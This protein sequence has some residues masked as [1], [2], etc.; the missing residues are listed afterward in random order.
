MIQK[1]K[2]RYEQYIAQAREARRKA[3]LCD[4]LFG[5]GNDPRKNPCHD[6]FY[7]AVGQWVSAF[8]ASN[9]NPED[10]AEAVAWILQAAYLNREQRDVY[11]YL[12]A[13][14]G[15]ALPLIQK[16]FQTDAKALLDWYG[17]TYPR[18]DRMPVQD[19][20]YGELKKTARMTRRQGGI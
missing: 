15:H 13:A 14:Q 17:R 3:G 20:V 9:P 2:D 6:S 5:M 7:D 11:D 19:N 18:R 1:L 4:G 12:Y 16:M 10:C 8:L